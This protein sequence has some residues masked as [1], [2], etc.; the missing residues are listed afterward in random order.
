MESI[1]LYYKEGASDKVYQANLESKGDGFIVTFAYGRRGSTLNTG[2]K[3]H[4]PVP[5]ETA[6]DIFN[7][8]IKD[9]TAKGYT[10]GEDGTPY[11]HTDTADEASGV[12]CQLLNPIE[13]THIPRYLNDA[14]FCL[15]EKFD[16]HR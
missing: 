15:Q 3:T 1:T 2:A 7:K 16:G 11:Q 13:E 8:L 12:H 9:K 6:K 14:R 10:P 5:Y 4:S